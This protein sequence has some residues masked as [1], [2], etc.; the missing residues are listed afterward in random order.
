MLISPKSFLNWNIFGGKKHYIILMTT[1]ARWE[2][3]C[4]FSFFTKVKGEGSWTPST[5]QSP[6]SF[7][8]GSQFANVPVRQ[9]KIKR[10]FTDP[11]Y[12][13]LK[14]HEGEDNEPGNKYVSINNNQSC[15]LKTQFCLHI[16]RQLSLNIRTWREQLITNTSV[17]SGFFESGNHILVENQTLST[18]K[19][20]EI[21]VCCTK[22]INEW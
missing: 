7:Q 18:E 1:Y 6:N 9:T 13:S 17:A 19:M 15:S 21:S 11:T 12:G 10:R 20:E 2:T 5:C 16:F 22:S 3:V 14:F 4:G 8:P